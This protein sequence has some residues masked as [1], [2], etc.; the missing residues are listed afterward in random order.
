MLL[1][2]VIGICELGLLFKATEYEFI[3]VG[4][5]TEAV[6]VGAEP[7]LYKF[8][9]KIVWPIC[10]PLLLFISAIFLLYFEIPPTSLYASGLAA[11]NESKFLDIFERK[12]L[13][14]GCNVL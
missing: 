2:F 8:S 9:A 14:Q 4:L 11:V 1:I 3:P 5:L 6:V 12:T 13:L 10:F 7:G